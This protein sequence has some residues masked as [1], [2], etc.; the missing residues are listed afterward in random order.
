MH[1][2]KVTGNYKMTWKIALYISF[3]GSKKVLS[4]FSGVRLLIISA[5]KQSKKSQTA[6]NIT[7]AFYDQRCNDK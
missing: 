4:E 3:Y 5:A 6:S 7:R 1:G 2:I